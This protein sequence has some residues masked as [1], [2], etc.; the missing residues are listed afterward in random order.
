MNIE[1]IEHI[2]IFEVCD[3]CDTKII[4]YYFS[5]FHSNTK[6]HPKIIHED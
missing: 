2:K 6:Y 4:R 1:D 3:S 5:N